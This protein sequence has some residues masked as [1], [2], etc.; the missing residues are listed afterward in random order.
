MANIL[1]LT[2]TYP[3]P[4]KKIYGST[5]VC[6]Y[7]AKEWVRQGC[8]VKVIYNYTVYPKF[9]HALGKTFG[10]SIAN[11]FPVPINECHYNKSFSYTIDGVEVL[12][13]PIFKI[14]PKMPF[15]MSS[16]KKNVGRTLKW[17]NFKGF[18]PDVIVGHFLHPSIEISRFLKDNY[19]SKVLITIHG[20]RRL[21]LDYYPIKKYGNIVD[22]WGYRSKTIMNSYADSI[23]GKRGFLCLS[24]IPSDYIDSYECSKFKL[25]KRLNVVF[26]GNLIKRKYPV[27]LLKAF[28]G[29]C[30]I[31]DDLT[32]IGDGSER[33][34]LEKIIKKNNLKNV[35]LLGRIPRNDVQEQLREKNIFVMIS[36]NETFG[37]VYLEAMAAGCIVVASRN[38]GMEGIIENGVN[39]YLCDAGNEHELET[40]L[41]KIKYQTDEQ[42]N[43]IIKN[44]RNTA[45]KLTDKVV[46]ENYLNE[47][48]HLI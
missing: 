47:I 9:F 43:E 32:Y 25:F 16:I 19:S 35:T 12:V 31:E 17:L 4:G 1:L 30:S 20:K 7:F 2:S 23:R 29:M 22:L 37:L 41:R 13:N 27:A 24:G 21:L 14:F 42:N 40:I 44:A 8:N 10:P 45:L 26:V 28:C 39:G 48:T 11:F 15:L 5:D 38:E 6:H 33:H 46:A 18:V 36:K 34:R 3:I